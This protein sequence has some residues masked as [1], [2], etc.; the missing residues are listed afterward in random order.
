M[1]EADIPIRPLPESSPKALSRLVLGTVQFGLPYGVSNSGGQPSY[2]TARDILAC[3]IE[4]GVTCLDT[5]AVYGES[6]AVLGRALAELGAAERVTV[7]TKVT[8][9]AADLSPSRADE[10]IEE[11]VRN[12]L[13]QL[14]LE[15][16]PFCFLHREE[17]FRYADSLL[18]LRDRGLVER[19]GSS[20]AT[21]AATKAIIGSGL[22]D[23]VQFP[24]SV[25]DRRFSGP[26][27]A[28]VA[29]SRGMDVF[30]RSIYL[31]GLVF[32]SDAKT[33][34]ALCDVIPARRR[35]AELAHDAGIP[36]AELALRYVLGLG[37]LTSILVGVDSVA[38]MR[39]NLAL[40]AKGPLPPDL[41]RAVMESV[42][43]LSD[44]ILDPWRWARQTTDQKPKA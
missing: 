35:L 39:E 19:I 11:S 1:H 16:L 33:P 8:H 25:L 5:A 23:A 17:D 3:A 15:R 27:V 41:M 44:A 28:G 29:C 4:G 6:E 22:A 20:T 12:S 42:P 10:L 26:D 21:P 43:S 40:F 7:V 30:A 34:E 24:A 31:Q 18:K 9:L 38:Q 36:L 13:R 37:D 32:L 2:E 14:R